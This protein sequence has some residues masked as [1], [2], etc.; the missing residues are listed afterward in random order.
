MFMDIS[1]CD[2]NN[3]VKQGE[4]CLLTG[5]NYKLYVNRWL[6]T[7]WTLHYYIYILI[8]ILSNL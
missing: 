3:W 7:Q 1:I 4:I 8:Y 6:R 2:T 5:L